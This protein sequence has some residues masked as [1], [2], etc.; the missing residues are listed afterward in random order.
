[1]ELGGKGTTSMMAVLPLP[2][3]AIGLCDDAA[4]FPPGLAPLAEAVPAHRRHRRSPY[5]AMVGPLVLATPMLGDLGP[6]L[7]DGDDRLGLSITAPAGPGQAAAALASAAALPVE[8]RGLE[9]AVPAGMSPAE[10]FAALDRIEGG[11]IPIFVEVPRDER[12][13]EII[14]MLPA[15]GRCAKFRTG[16]VTA[17]LY[18][19][20]AELAA[21]VEAVVRAG[22]PFK[23]TAGLHHPTRNTDPDTGFDQHGFLN[24]LLA[25]DDALA[26]GSTADLAVTLAERDAEAV[27]VRVAGLDAARVSA[28]RA[29]FRSFGTCSI[30]DPLTDLVDLGLV[31]D[32]VAGAPEGNA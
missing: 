20:P 5:A 13:A 3:F 17:E 12:R 7:G 31:P 30:T 19:D 28:A 24:L 8:V 16:G 14:A 23:A 9:I 11:D 1:V 22:V 32:A 21:M 6:L 27:A 15:G 26:G 2:A 29:R 10:F 4:V 25:V 18:P